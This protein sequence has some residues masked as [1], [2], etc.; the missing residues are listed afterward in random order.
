M[1]QEASGW[2]PGLER[3]IEH[4]N[5]GKM[6][7]RATLICGLALLLIRIASKHFP[8]EATDFDM[9]FAIMLGSTLSRGINGSAPFL[10]AVRATAA[11]VPAPFA[12][13]AP[14]PWHSGAVR[15]SGNRTFGGVLLGD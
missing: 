8:S 2:L 4:F 3:S 15:R 6:V 7:L 13:S 1:L 10:P 14:P 5:S 12:H 11:T 9:I